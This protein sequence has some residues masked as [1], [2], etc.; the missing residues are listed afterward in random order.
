MPRRWLG[1][2]R[3]G[4]PVGQGRVA[5]ISNSAEEL[6]RDHGITY[7]ITINDSSGA[8]NSELQPGWYVGPSRALSPDRP[9]TSIQLLKRDLHLMRDTGDAVRGEIVRLG[10]GQPSSLTVQ[11]HQ[12]LYRAY[13]GSYL[14]ARDTNLTIAQRRA[15]A[16]AN[17]LGPTDVTGATLR[18]RV[19]NYFTHFSG[20]SPTSWISFANPNDGTRTT[21]LTAYVVSG[22]IGTDV[23][24]VDRDWIN[25]LT[26]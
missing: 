13:G 18:E 26:A 12:W 5:A 10:G 19:L 16:V 24:L 9:A 22:D 6:R 25:A 8:W 14:I 20:D 23:D 2:V 1:L 4:L 3:E 11:A 17:R 21:L 15:W 7:F